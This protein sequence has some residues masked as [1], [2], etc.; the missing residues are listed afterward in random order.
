MK[1]IAIYSPKGGVGR[2]TL[3]LHLADRLTAAGR[4]VFLRDQDPQASAL[5]FALL[6]EQAGASL[7]FTVGRGVPPQGTDI[8]ISDYGPQ[9]LPMLPAADLII[10]PVGMDGV[11]FSVGLRTLDRLARTGAAVLP[12]VSRFR[13]DRAE[14]RAALAD[15]TLA[16]AVIIHDRASLAGFYA[17]G[18]LV[19]DPAYGKQRSAVVA[20]ADLDTLTAAVLERLDPMGLPDVFADV[21]LTAAVS[22]G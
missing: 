12:V 11:S 5:A 14:H 10:V 21:F 1:Q 8:T 7:N 13:A 20:R 18:R 3:S 17:Q 9:E 15:K 16:D 19:H 22:R 6:A 4:H 2:T